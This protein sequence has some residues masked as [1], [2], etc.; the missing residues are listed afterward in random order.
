M[1]RPITISISDSDFAYLKEKKLSPSKFLRQSIN[2]KRGMESLKAEHPEVEE[3]IEATSWIKRLYDKIFFFKSSCK[4]PTIG[5]TS[6][7]RS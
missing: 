1:H 5:S 6:N 2:Y 3:E 4:P 7:G